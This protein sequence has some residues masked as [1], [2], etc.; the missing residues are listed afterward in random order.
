MN[1]LKINRIK[2]HLPLLPSRGTTEQRLQKA[3]V[4]NYSF[5]DALQYEFKKDMITPASFIKVLQNV[6]GAKIGL[7]IGKANDKL[8]SFVKYCLNQK[9]CCNG[10]FLQLPFANFEEKIHKSSAPIF[11]KETQNLMN[12]V[13]NPKFMQ[14]YANIVNKGYNIDAMVDFYKNNIE[15]TN[16]LSTDSL[17]KFLSNK[18]AREKIDT[19]QFLRYRLMSE[20]NTE[21]ASYQIDKKIE[22]H[23]KLKFIRPNNYYDLGKYK[24]DEKIQILNNKLLEII[25]SERNL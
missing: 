4:L 20:K 16:M 17:E 1:R 25:Q 24:Y 6:V 14:R 15:K 5:Y 10:Y 7:S 18:A 2:T 13:L 11:L 12:E 23:N 8:G 19:L 21:F 3:R 9:L 22:Y